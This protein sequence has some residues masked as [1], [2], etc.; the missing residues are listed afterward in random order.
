MALALAAG[1]LAA[2]TYLDGK[3]QLRRD[4]STLYK[5]RRAGKAYDKALKDDKISPWY[6]LDE[7]CARY[8]QNRAIWTRNGEWTFQQFRDETVRYAQWMLQQGIR[9]GDLVAMYL[10]NSAEYLM[11]FFATLSIGAGPALINYNLE[12]KALMHCLDV[13]QS[14][15]LIVDDDAGC[16]QRIEAKRQEIDNAGA[17]IVTLSADLKRHVGSMPTTVPEDRLR[18]GMKG[19][20]PYA[21]IYTS[22]TTGLPKGCPFTVSRIWHLGNYIEPAF[23]A[24]SG[25]DCWYSPMPLYHGT[26]LITTSSALL[27]GIGVAIAPRF[28]VKNFWPDIHDSRSTLF[29]YVGETARYLLAAPPHPL[30]RDHILRVAYGNGLR[31]DVWHKLQERFNIPE[32]GEF[33]NSSE[34]MFQLLNYATGPYT[35]ACVGHHGLLLRT[36]LQNVYIPVAID[37]DTGDI[38]RD[39]KTG[40]AQRTPYEEGGEI[41]VKVGTKEEFGG[42]WRNPDATNKRFAT[43]LFVKGDLY[44]RSGDALRRSPDGHWYFMDR[45]G[46]TFRWKSENVST[47]EVGEVLGHYPGIK[48][49]NVYGVTVPGHEGRAGC[50]ALHL[51]TPPNQAFFSDLLQYCRARLPRYAVPV[52]LRIVKGS[53]HIHNHKQNKVGLR[54]EG[55]DP[56][57][58]GTI[59]KEGGED[60]FYWW[61]P[62]TDAYEPF[63]KKDWGTLSKGQARL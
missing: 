17:K 15:L 11:I 32:V 49:A 43:D 62:E 53:S 51:T 31:P 30:E 58:V 20:W 12:D 25:R 44:Y 26:G 48:E 7:A 33:F 57:K 61:R 45:L 8:P 63:T 28:S 4:A 23:N 3:Y 59:E 38:W 39:P 47:A 16:Q 54:Q 24:K 42:Y 56:D 37:V 13:A 50:A 36:A 60:V 5:M 46:D 41:L 6:L 35:N 52:F 34:G 10:T 29:I 27:G 21:L 55:V 9:P 19:E 1:G 40:F 14:K 2:A 22:G 18:S